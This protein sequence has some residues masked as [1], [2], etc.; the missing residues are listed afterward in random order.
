MPRD[1]QFAN[2]RMLSVFLDRTLRA[3]FFVTTVILFAWL[4]YNRKCGLNLSDEG[5]YLNFIANLLIY[6]PSLCDFV[7]HW[8]CQW[9]GGDIAV[10]RLANVT[11]TMALGSILS[12]FVIRRHWTAGWVLSIGIASLTLCD[13]RNWW[14]TPSYFALTLQSFLMIMIGSL[15]A[16]R[17]G[18]LLRVLGWALVGVG[19]WCRFFETVEVLHATI[20]WANC[21]AELENA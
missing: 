12:L 13:F 6:A 18:H 8:S 4:P 9:A 21:Q 10:L 5:S 2:G 14:L 17:L 15:L 20:V 7:D 16:D 1:D 3:L 11:L 19:G